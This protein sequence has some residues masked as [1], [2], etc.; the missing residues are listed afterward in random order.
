[1]SFVM[2]FLY[3]TNEGMKKKQEDCLKTAILQCFN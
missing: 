1:M 3:Y 2:S